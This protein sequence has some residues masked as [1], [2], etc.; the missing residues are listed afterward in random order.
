VEKNTLT[1]GVEDQVDIV[2]PGVRALKRLNTAATNTVY[3]GIDDTRGAVFVKISR[4]PLPADEYRSL[5]HEASVIVDIQEK[6]HSPRLLPWAHV[7]YAGNVAALIAPYIEAKTLFEA[8]TQ[9]LSFRASIPLAYDLI[10]AVDEIKTAGYSHFDIKPTNVLYTPQRE[11]RI[12]LVDF[13][14]GRLRPFPPTPDD[15]VICGTLGYMPPL[16]LQHCFDDKADVFAAGATLCQLLTHKDA[17]PL[18][19]YRG[20][21]PADI[22]AVHMLR[23]GKPIFPVGCFRKYFNK[24]FVRLL[25]SMAHAWHENRPSSEEAVKEIDALV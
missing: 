4:K 11:A 9:G 17:Y 13:N 20:A 21:L 15:S 6:V 14:L 12:V 24:R 8:Y 5:E 19:Q 18:P 16:T 23:Q 22:V 1:V 3:A 25:E 2:F 10:H 7:T